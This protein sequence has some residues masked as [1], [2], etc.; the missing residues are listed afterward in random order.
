MS[1]KDIQQR[2]AVLGRHA[3]HPPAAASLRAVMTRRHPFNVPL[4]RQRDDHILPPIKLLLI[5]ISAAINHISLARIAKLLANLLNIS[6]DKPKDRRR[7]S[8][9]ALQIINPRAHR[10]IFILQFL[11]FQC[12]QT[13][14][15]HIKNSVRLGLIKRKIDHQLRAGRIHIRRPANNLNH[16]VNMRNRLKQTSQNMSARPLPPQ[17]IFRTAHDNPIAML[18]VNPQ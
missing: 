8:Q 1:E 6:A 17:V 3:A 15:L 12:R 16:A 2:I 4:P 13:A 10:T 7:R 9:Q 11:P 14:Q 18:N 5:K